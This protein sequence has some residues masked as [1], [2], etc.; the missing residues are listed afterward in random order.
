MD[1]SFALGIGTPAT[2]NR[3][4]EGSGHRAKGA[5]PVAQAL[6]DV[7]AESDYEDRMGGSHLATG[8]SQITSRLLEQLASGDERSRTNGALAAREVQRDF[9][10]SRVPLD[11]SPPVSWSRVIVV[12]ADGKMLALVCLPVLR[13]AL[14]KR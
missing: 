11:A 5:A 13:R 6:V 1:E 14:E 8:L 2:A 7:L 10:G 12:S 4:D 3:D 9:R